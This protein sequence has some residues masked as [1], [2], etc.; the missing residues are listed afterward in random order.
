MRIQNALC[1]AVNVLCAARL[2]AA[3]PSLESAPPVVVKTVPVAG[4]AEVDPA[5]TELRVTYSKRMQ[6]GS[7]SWAT[8]S[9]ESYPETAGTPHYL[10]DGKTCVLP[11]KLAPGKF[12]ATWLNSDKFKNF[13]DADGRPALPYLLT[14]R[15]GESKPESPA[16]GAE[17]GEAGKAIVPSGGFLPGLNADQQAVLAWT[18]RQFRGF[19][20]RRTFEGW[21]EAD[22][23]AEETKL[24]DMLKGPQ[25]REYFLAINTLGAMHSTRGLP[26][27]REI[28][29]DRADKNNRDRWMSI[30]SIGLIG[31][32]RDVP[33]LAHLVYHGN[34][35]TRWWAQI[36]LVKITGQN[37]AGDWEAWG[38]WWNA[39]NGQPPF[40]PE[41]IRWWEGQPGNDKL[42]QALRESD[43]KFLDEIQ[44]KPSAEGDTK[45]QAGGAV[46][47]EPVPGLSAASVLQHDDGIKTG[48][49]SISGSGHAVRFTRPA[50]KRYVEAVQIFGSRYG[51]PEPPQEDFHLYI[52]NDKQQVL[53][54]L[55]FAYS[56]IN[57]GDMKW[58][59]LRTPSIEVPEQFMVAL[60]FNP[61]QTKGIY[62]A[63]SATNGAAC[64]SLIGLP[65]DGYEPWKPAEWMVRV[66]LMAEPTKEKGLKELSDWRPPAVTD[67]FAAARLVVLGGDRSEGMQSYGGQGPAVRFKPAELLA[68]AKP[69]ETLI[70]KGV[71]F[72]GSRYGV[73]YSPGDTMLKVL[74][75]DAKG[76][77]LAE[78]AFPYAQLGYRAKW[79][80]LVFT[81]PVTIANP[82]EPIIVAFD[83]EA[84]QS[85]GVYFH[86]QK[87]PLTSH[88][89]VGTA[90]KGFKE[91]AGREWMVR[92]AF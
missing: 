90:E 17:G 35:N 47:P 82:A 57:R 83:P 33:E 68:D 76:T 2:A 42:A 19:F 15:T 81:T 36:A 52:L 12:Y 22:R 45:L 40:R 60:N 66:S 28:A 44:P 56:L 31:D 41:I 88:S 16:A 53:A 54:D 61:H 55:P 91:T 34:V 59:T 89:L 4:S 71:R 43:R 23:S 46:Q 26:A 18:D 58:H 30:R 73:G 84:T 75:L 62:L 65:E 37:F 48:M 32:Q 29:Y 64:Y 38:K 24:I 5:L 3:E 51:T 72:F 39:R 25:T 78:A 70:L 92:V 87:D 69:G 63:Y 14:F 85:K 7:W 11:V 74:V 86:Y 6:P 10:P 67:P 49:E 79:T 27:L 50:D 9:A 8:W 80:D 20:D 13:T 1:L 21:T 77:K